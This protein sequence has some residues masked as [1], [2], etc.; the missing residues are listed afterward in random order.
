MC[1][2][3]DSGGINDSGINGSVSSCVED[4]NVVIVVAVVISVEEV[5]LESTTTLKLSLSTI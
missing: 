2:G 5:V 3:C 1:R 4:V